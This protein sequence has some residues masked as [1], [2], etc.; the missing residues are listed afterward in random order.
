MGF[1]EC[2]DTPLKTGLFK[3]HSTPL[4]TGLFKVHSTPLKTGL[5]KV[6]STPL[7][8][9]LFKKH[10]HPFENRAFQSAQIPLWK[11]G[12]S[13]CT[14]PLWKQ[15]FSKCTDT[16]LK[17]GLFKKHRHPFENRAFQ[18][19]D[20][21]L[22][23]S[24]WHTRWSV[25]GFL[26]VYR[27]PLELTS[28][29]STYQSDSC[30]MSVQHTY[31]SMYAHNQDK[32]QKLNNN[33]KAGGDLKKKEKKKGISCL[34]DKDAVGLNEV[35]NGWH[36]LRRQIWGFPGVSRCDVRCQIRIFPGFRLSL[37]ATKPT[38]GFLSRSNSCTTTPIPEF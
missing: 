32:K 22:K 15:G 18:S 35:V 30:C 12:F 8:T 19:A 37:H 2:T 9:G 4:K 3:V 21:P 24:F 10:R 27:Y 34:L 23:T 13:K 17:T 25:Y 1:L 26:R 6:H 14:A 33:N 20:T 28:M 38:G 36:E 29:T 16:P 11:Q 7:K 31:A 5:F